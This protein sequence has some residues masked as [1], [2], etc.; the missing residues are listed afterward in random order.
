MAG[1]TWNVVVVVTYCKVLSRCP[2][3]KLGISTKA[4]AKIAGSRAELYHCICGLEN[5]IIK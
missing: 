3:R 2:F 5:K 1:M 4:T